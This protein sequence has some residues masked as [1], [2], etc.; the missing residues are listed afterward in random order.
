MDTLLNWDIKILEI[1]NLKM[2]NPVLDTV[3]PFI[4]REFVVFVPIVILAFV[5]IL[6]GQ[7]KLRRFSVLFVL[8]FLCTYGVSIF[9]KYIIHR[10]RPMNMIHIRRLLIGIE[11]ENFSFPSTHSAIVFALAYLF[12]VKHRSL[13]PYAYFAAAF[14]AWARVYVGVHYPSD[15][16]FGALLG[17]AISKILIVIERKYFQNQTT[18]LS[19]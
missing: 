11:P 4:G 12:W 16:L 17:I 15:V 7:N 19:P 2:T 18:D 9:L 3:F 5:L 10:P 6:V 8:S 13:A 14:V 1:M